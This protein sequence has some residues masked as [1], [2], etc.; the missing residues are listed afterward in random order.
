MALKVF[1]QEVPVGPD[2][3]VSYTHFEQPPIPWL[4]P[5][6]RSDQNHCHLVFLYFL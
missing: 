3:F 6:G 2:K 1:Q 4:K 5:P